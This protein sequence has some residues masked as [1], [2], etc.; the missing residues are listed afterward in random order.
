MYTVLCNSTVVW[1][2][3]CVVLLTQL[4]ECS[5]RLQSVVGSNPTNRA[6]LLC[7]LEKRAVLGIVDLFVVPLPFSIT[8]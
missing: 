5:P 4:V 7:S 3:S 6:A 8:L 1:D 2:L